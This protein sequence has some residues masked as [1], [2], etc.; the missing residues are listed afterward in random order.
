MFNS[1]AHEKTILNLVKTRK[2]DIMSVKNPSKRNDA[3]PCFPPGHVRMDDEEKTLLSL[4]LLHDIKKKIPNSKL[5]FD[6]EKNKVQL[7]FSTVNQEHTKDLLKKLQVALRGD[8]VFVNNSKDLVLI[9]KAL[10]SVNAPTSKVELTIGLTCFKCHYGFPEGKEG[11]E[12]YRNH[13]M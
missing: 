4:A 7:S 12:E 9:H 3:G 11:L 6:E 8:S 1:L 10:K 2:K 13:L 5:V